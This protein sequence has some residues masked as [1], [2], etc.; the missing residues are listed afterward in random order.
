MKTYDYLVVG[1]GLFGAVFAY[2]VYKLTNDWRLC[3]MIGGGLGIGLLLLRIS[4]TESGMFHSLKEQVGIQQTGN[5]IHHPTSN[6]A[7]DG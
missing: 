4:V 1:A 6:M 7:F 5:K 3:Y 2:F